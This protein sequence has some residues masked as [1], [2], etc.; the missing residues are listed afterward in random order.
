[1]LSANDIAGELSTVRDYLRFAVS[2]FSA[3]GLAYG[4]GTSNALDEAAFIILEALDLP[5]DD[6]NPW[7]DARLTFPER[8]RVG[9]LILDRVETRKPA[10]YL[11]GRA[12]VQGVPFRVD[13]RVI[14]PRSYIG[15]L[16]AAG[17]FSGQGLCLIEEPSEVARV[18]DLCTG[19]GC[20]A[21]LAGLAFPDARVDAVDLSTDALEVARLNVADHALG[22]RVKLLHGD[23]YAPLGDARYDLIL[24]NPPYVDAEA[25]DDLPAEF[26]CEPVMALAGG[27]DGL[28]LVRRIIAGAGEHLNPGGGLVC[29]VGRAGAALEGALPD[30]PFLWLD[31]EESEHEVFWLPAEALAA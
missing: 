13:E 31:T 14:V 20:L 22:E 1:M 4:Q 21:I 23:L 18:L 19:S 15:E 16:L 6:I 3:A 5:V 24:T 27:E 7:L 9:G 25:M 30:L 11:L 10:A 8:L 28:D 12:Y 2:R 29:E 26:R 17:H